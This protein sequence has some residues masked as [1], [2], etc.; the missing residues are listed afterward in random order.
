MIKPD[1]LV[2]RLAETSGC[3][4]ETRCPNVRPANT[5]LRKLGFSR[6]RVLDLP[7]TLKDDWSDR[8]H[9]VEKGEATD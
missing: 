6:V 2:R 4:P 9:P 7:T 1:D 5:E 8:G 3:C